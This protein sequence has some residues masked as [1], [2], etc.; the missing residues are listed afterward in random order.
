MGGAVHLLAAVLDRPARVR[1]LDVLVPG[2]GPLA[3]GAE[4][5]G[6]H[7]PGV[8]PG[9]AVAVQH[10][11]LPD[12][13]G[14]RGRLP[15]AQRL[16]LPVP[17][18]GHRPGRDRGQGPPLPGAGRLLLP[19]LGDAVRAVDGQDPRAD[20]RDGGAQL[21]AA[22]RQGG[23][24]RGHRG[25]RHGLGVRAPAQLPP[26]GRPGP[27]A[28]AVPLRVPQ[29][30]LRRLPG[31]LRLLQA[32]LPQHPRPG[33]RQDGRRGRGRPVPARRG[34]EEAGPPGR[35]L[36]RRRRLRPAIGGRGDRGPA[37]QRRRA[38]VA[39]AVGGVGPAV[40][41][42]LG[43]QRLLPHRRGVAGAPGDP[44]RV[45]ARLHRQA[46]RRGRHQPTHRRHPGR[47]R[48]DRRRVRRAAG[49]RRGPGRLRA[50][51]RPGP[52]GVPLCREPQL[53]RRALE[54]LGAVAQDAPARRRAGQ[55]GLLRRRGR[56][57]PAQ[58]G[59][60]PRGAVGLLQRLGGRHPAAGAGLLG[61]G[62]GAAPGHPE[63]AAV[64][65]APA[66]PGPAA[67]GR[68]RAV[69]HHALGHHRRERQ[70][71]AGGRRRCRRRHPQGLRRLPGGGRGAGPGDL[72]GR[73]DRRDPGG[74]DPGR[75]PD[76]ARAGPPSSAR[77]GPP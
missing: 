13:A 2:R 57:L 22:A 9:L 1:G 12:P 45:R 40:V 49:H 27:A 69:H 73:P 59:R 62:A 23:P 76:R 35:R 30:R 29:P 66:R 36:R 20:R 28:V 77:S 74:R 70:A 75:P 54:P 33:H 18:R 8:R 58:A 4:P 55:G 16:R 53:L 61:P 42:L 5:L 56:H 63:R 11:P 32:G 39:V 72:L 38:G 21:R 14:P 65:V 24:G 7:L 50:E 34:A 10:P 68:D 67:R 37:G 64:L 60:G 71:V 52:G 31:L 46:P 44:V 41:Q 51:A 48:P 6:R 25:P 15:A 47:A 26:A 43:R 3:G 19:E 17:G